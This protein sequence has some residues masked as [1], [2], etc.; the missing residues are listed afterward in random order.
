MQI[1]AYI[2]QFVILVVKNNE[3]IS[4]LN[5]IEIIFNKA[6]TYHLVIICNMYTWTKIV[7]LECS[8]VDEYN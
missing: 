6:V 2:I 3:E 7:E 4:N 1:H 5:I 8:G